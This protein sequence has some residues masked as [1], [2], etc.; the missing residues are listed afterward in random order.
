MCGLFVFDRAIG[1]IKLDLKRMHE[2]LM[3]LWCSP[4]ICTRGFNEL[5]HQYR[6]VFIEELVASVGFVAGN[7]DELN[8]YPEGCVLKYRWDKIT[9]I[10]SLTMIVTTECTCNLSWNIIHRINIE[11]VL[12][13]NVD[14]GTSSA[15]NERRV[16][17]NIKSGILQLADLHDVNINESDINT[18]ARTFNK[19][20]IDKYII[21]P[22]VTNNDEPAPDDNIEL[23]VDFAQH[24]AHDNINEAIEILYDHME[25][26]D[27]GVETGSN[28]IDDI[29][30]PLEV[31]LE[32]D[33][34]SNVSSLDSF[35]SI[36]ICGIS[37]ELINLLNKRDNCI[38]L[39][40]PDEYFN[41]VDSTLSIIKREL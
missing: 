40:D 34:S 8:V 9:I 19:T 5:I 20:R 27:E 4:N 1:Y 30:V 28:S 31:Q 23:L 25:N 15:A 18:H 26:T 37:E 3:S 14:A 32:S 17:E 29:Q 11:H 22:D 2:N 39:Y 24:F 36:G 12:E 7:F 13:N 38:A 35:P 6:C 16:T 10:V 41:T 33:S 21:V